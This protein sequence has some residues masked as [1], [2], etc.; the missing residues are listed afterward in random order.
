MRHNA[1]VHWLSP[2][3]RG[4]AKLPAT[5]R[6]IGISRFSEDESS[7]PGDAWSVELRFKTPPPESMSRDITEATV[8][9]WVVEAPHER[10]HAG[11]RFGLFEGNTKVADVDVLD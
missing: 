2:K 5:L 10:L 4:T 6:Y 7:P 3:E 11:V 1:L 9:F 8:Q